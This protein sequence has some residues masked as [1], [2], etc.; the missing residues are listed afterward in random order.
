M[1]FL[2]RLL[3]SIFFV[4][5]VSYQK[6]IVPNC[7]KKLL[8]PLVLLCGANIANAQ[9]LPMPGTKNPDWKLEKSEAKKFENLP[10]APPPATDR[11]P[12]ALPK[13][14][15]SIG[16][17]H[18]YWDADRQLAYEWQSG[19]ESVRPEN[20]VTVIEQR[21]GTAYMYRRLTQLK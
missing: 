2:I 3:R 9:L 12:N 20:Q 14:I 21:T 18:S 5:G 10:V 16:N 13:T 8:L 4:A 19:P 6:S 15:K 11:M 7:T 1:T 17:R